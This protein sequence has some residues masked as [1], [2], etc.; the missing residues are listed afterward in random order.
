MKER[1]KLKVYKRTSNNGKDMPMIVLQGNW[2]INHGFSHG[3][4]IAVEC[5]ENDLHIVKR[6]PDA[7]ELETLSE[8]IGKLTPA[9][10]RKVSAALDEMGV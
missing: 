4:F 6:D 10:K 7:S 8:R 5:E 3:D 2:L 1:R 9:Q